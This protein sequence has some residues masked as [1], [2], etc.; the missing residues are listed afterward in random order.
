M[1]RNSLPKFCFQTYLQFADPCIVLPKQK[2]STKCEF[3][4]SPDSLA[5]H[6]LQKQLDSRTS[7]IPGVP[8]LRTE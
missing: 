4:H 5:K 7:I 3:L 8:T 6:T 2:S 1:V